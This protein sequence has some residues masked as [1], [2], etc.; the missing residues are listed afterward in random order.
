MGGFAFLPNNDNLVCGKDFQ[1]LGDIHGITVSIKGQE[2]P[3][4]WVLSNEPHLPDLFADFWRNNDTCFIDHES[5]GIHNDL[6]TRRSFKI[7]WEI[8]ELPPIN[9]SS[10]CKK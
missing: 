1:G 7:I 2:Y 9:V 8:L 4:A 10:L 5:V 6:G 3:T